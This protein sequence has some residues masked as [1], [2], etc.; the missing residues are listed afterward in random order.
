MGYKSTLLY[1]TP[2]LTQEQKHAHVQWVIQHNDDHCSRTMFTDE[3]CYQLLRDTIS[4]WS[5]NPSTEVKRRTK[6]EQKIM[7]SRGISI[8]GPIGY[9]SFKTIMYGSYC[10][11]ILQDPLI[12]NAR[13]QF[14]R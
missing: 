8:K 10:V 2:M 11:Q 1:V 13:R 9:H 3:T 12:L 5:R 7:V 6:S 14:G 4:R